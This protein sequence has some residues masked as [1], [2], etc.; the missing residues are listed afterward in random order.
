MGSKEVKA[1]K[2]AEVVHQGQKR[3]GSG[4]DYI[5]HPIDV[6][7]L[8]SR[9][10]NDSDILAAALLHDAVEDTDLTYQEIE[11]K[12]GSRVANIIR[13]VSTTKKDKKTL[14]WKERKQ[15][16]VRSIAT[17]T[18]EAQLV[19]IADKV[20]NAKDLTKLWDEN[21]V[22]HFDNFK[23]KDP[24]LQEW[25]Y[26]SLYEEFARNAK[27]KEV[28]SLAEELNEYVSLAFG[29]SYSE[30]REEGDKVLPCISK[31][32]ENTLVKKL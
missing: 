14:S 31:T 7:N 20:S 26:R 10:S 23:E 27:R 8:V 1:K 21:G 4:E 3:K 15:N 2:L 17:L 29:R 19:E 24:T 28:M 32:E 30:Y 13:E 12:L 11:N 16:T 25:Y 9:Y 18:E 22:I 5:K 6:Y